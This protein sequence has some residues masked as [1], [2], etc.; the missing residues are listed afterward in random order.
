MVRYELDIDFTH[1]FGTHWH[2]GT[3]WQISR[4]SK[5]R[6][7]QKVGT[8]G[9]KGWSAYIFIRAIAVPSESLAIETAES[10]A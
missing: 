9:Y 3:H 1:H 10:S 6:W 8:G 2:S 4:D 5:P 7:I